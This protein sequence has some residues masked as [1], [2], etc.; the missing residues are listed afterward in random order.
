MNYD[1]DS[2][3]KFIESFDG[4]SV[5]SQTSGCVLYSLPVSACIF[6]FTQIA[7]NTC[8]GLHVNVSCDNRR[9]TITLL[10]D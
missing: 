4:V 9:F 1:F 5:L 8:D 2:A 7:P 10:S 3:K 6:A